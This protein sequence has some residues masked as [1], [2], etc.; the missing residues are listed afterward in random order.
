MWVRVWNAKLADRELRSPPK[1]YLPH[2]RLRPAP[3]GLWDIAVLVEEVRSRLEP[4]RCDDPR[5]P[6][7][8]PSQQA[9]LASEPTSLAKLINTLVP[10]PEGPTA[11]PAPLPRYLVGGPGV[12]RDHQQGNGIWRRTSTGTGTPSPTARSLTPSPP[13]GAPGV[14]ATSAGV[15]SRCGTRALTRGRGGRC[16][17]TPRGA[18][19]GATRL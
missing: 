6:F 17:S 2:T 16:G 15:M 11:C 19:P 7:P 3:S 14:S 10:L 12:V 18:R 4:A 13:E 1:T 9:P 8:S 5:V